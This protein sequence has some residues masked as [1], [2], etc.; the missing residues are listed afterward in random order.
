MAGG[1]LWCFIKRFDYATWPFVFFSIQIDVSCLSFEGHQFQG[2]KAIM[3]KLNVSYLQIPHNSNAEGILLFI[4]LH[5]C[6]CRDAR[7]WSCLCEFVLNLICFFVC[8]FYLVHNR[9]FPS[10]R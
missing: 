1:V 8:L 6:V 2:K 7:I 3:D 9:V 4:F 10:Q 5:T